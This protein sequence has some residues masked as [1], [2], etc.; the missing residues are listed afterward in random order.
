LL[1]G[2][3]SVAASEKL[4]TMLGQRGLDFRVLNAVRLA[5]EAQIVAL[6]GEPGHIT[7]ATN[8]AGRGTDVKLGRGVA[9]LGGLHVIATERHESGRVDRQLFGRAARQGDAGSAQAFISAE[10]ELLR[11]HLPRGVR[12]LLVRV[13]KTRAPGHQKTTQAAFALAQRNAQNLAAKQR[14]AVLRTDTWLDESLSFAG[15]DTV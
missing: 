10:D 5:E 9:A 8:M 2:T 3:R 7:I 12:E 15:V 1:V 14:R 6:A 4:A 11:R 13:L